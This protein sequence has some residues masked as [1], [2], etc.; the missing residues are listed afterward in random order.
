[1]ENLTEK[2]MIFCTEYL[3]DM[4]GTRA[5]KAA[6]PHIKKDNTAAAAA[7]RLLRN[8]NVKA[9]IDK[10]LKEI[11]DSKIADMA[12]VLQRLTIA[13]RGELEEEVV[14]V[15]NIGDFMSKAS[16]IKKKI[17]AKDQLKALELLGKRYSLFTDKVDVDGDMQ[18]QIVDD[19][20]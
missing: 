12:E 13:A 3:R 14:V 10:K 20:E 1:M 9:Y 19:I 8:V 5:Y 4:N 6:Y 17:G 16:K 18:I 2:Q 7:S 11:E 15:E